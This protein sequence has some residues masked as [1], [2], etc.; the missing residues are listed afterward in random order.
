MYRE[1][2]TVLRREFLKWI[3]VP[4]WASGAIVIPFLYLIL[5]GQAFNLGHLFPGGSGGAVLEAAF[6]GA[7]D[8]FSYF[9]AGMVAFIA[10]GVALYAGTGVLFDNQLGI[11]PRLEASPAP[12]TALIGGSL[13]FRSLVAAVT[14]FFAIALGLLFAHVPGLAGLTINGSVTGVGVLEIVAATLL[15]SAMFTALFLAF[16]YVVTRNETYFGLTSLANFPI[17]FT[18][19]AMFPQG[20]MPGW[21]QTISAYNPVSLAVNVTRENLFAS[22]GYAYGPG[23]YLLGLGAWAVVLIGVSLLVITRK[24]RT[25]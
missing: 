13:V 1:F 24:L 8:Y 22:V 7:P 10:L 16:G 21:L 20:T 6:L 15:L 19:N 14:G 2:V 3:R 9:A 25:R 11:E 18:S 17:L 4:L 23:I 12:R 5:F